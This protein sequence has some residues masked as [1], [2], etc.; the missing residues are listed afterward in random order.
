MIAERAPAPRLRAFTKQR[1][2]KHSKWPPFI[3]VYKYNDDDDDGDK[4]GCARA[5]QRY[6]QDQ[7][8]TTERQQQ[9][10]NTKLS[11]R[12]S[13][14]ARPRSPFTVT[15]ID[16]L[17]LLLDWTT[18]RRDSSNCGCACVAQALFCSKRLAIR[19]QEG[20]HSG[21]SV[22]ILQPCIKGRARVRMPRFLLFFPAAL[23]F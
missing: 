23:S 12:V 8:K 13:P 3:Y 21:S 14:L 16:L 9:Q 7:N 1:R 17:S 18:A 22:C 4:A 2:A 20:V 6:K 11:F 15:T 5:S 10:Q 19:S